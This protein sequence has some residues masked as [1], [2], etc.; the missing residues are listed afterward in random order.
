MTERRHFAFI[1]AI[2]CVALLFQASDAVTQKNARPSE[3]KS[4]AKKDLQKQRGGQQNDSAGENLKH[5]GVIIQK[6][7]FR[8][9]GWGN[10]EKK[11]T[12][13]LSAVMAVISDT[14]EREE[15][16]AII[17]KLGGNSYYISEGDTFAG[18][19]EAVDVDEQKVKLDRSGEEIE[20]KLGEGTSSTR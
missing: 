17:E 3:T 2:L 8:P 14:S 13:A 9:L 12:Y 19:I 5:Y 7:L 4:A 16:R 1:T 10:E 20:L 11:P 18:G 15:G 6:N